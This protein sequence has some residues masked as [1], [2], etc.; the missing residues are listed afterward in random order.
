MGRV[1]SLLVE[2]KAG[3]LSCV[4]G[5]F[6]QR[7]YNIKSLNVA[8]TLDATLSRITLTTDTDQR[9]TEQ[10]VK[11][12]NKLVDVVKVVPYNP[13]SQ[14]V[15]E[16]ALVRVRVSEENRA[17]ILALSE[18]FRA[19]VIDVSPR[20]YIF[21]VTGQSEKIDAFLQNMRVYGIREI[22]RTGEL[23]LSRGRAE[24]KN[25]SSAVI[26]PPPLVDSKTKQMTSR[27]EVKANHG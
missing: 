12:L 21:E 27:S 7:G 14:V 10:V 24:K 23:A 22:H 1:I 3:V 5:L 4:V 15:R 20:G 9:G 6:S 13:S 19:R 17:E 26:Q 18:V 25:K 2:N 16:M 11:Q 8:P